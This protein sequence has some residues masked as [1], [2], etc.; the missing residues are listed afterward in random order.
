MNNM[1]NESKW[2]P[3]D[4]TKDNPEVQP[5][6]ERIV[7]V[8]SVGWEALYKDGELLLELIEIPYEIVAEEALKTNSVPK[9]ID[10]SNKCKERRLYIKAHFPNKLDDFYSI[11]KEGIK[12]REYEL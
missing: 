7:I 12:K 3:M 10:F 6:K 11:Q 2:G 5:E 8:R 1:D 9:V 4:P